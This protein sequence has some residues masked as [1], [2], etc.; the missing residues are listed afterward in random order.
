MEDNYLFMDQS[1]YDRENITEFIDVPE[2]KIEDEYE[3]LMLTSS[4]ISYG[5]VYNS[6]HASTQHSSYKSV[7]LTARLSRPFRVL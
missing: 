6:T 7:I 4:E 5:R 2:D 3:L 1:K